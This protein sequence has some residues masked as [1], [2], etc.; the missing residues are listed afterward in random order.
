[1]MIKIR[2]RLA[3]VSGT[4]ASHF[5]KKKFIRMIPNSR[6]RKIGINEK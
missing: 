1:M 5:E 3:L 6:E 4:S 2:D